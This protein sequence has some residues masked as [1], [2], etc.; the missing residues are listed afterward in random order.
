MKV[1]ILAGGRGTRLSEETNLI[2][3]PLVEIGGIPIIEHLIN[4]YTNQGFNDF[5][6][7]GGYKYEL[8]NSWK[9]KLKFNIRIDIVDTGLET[10]TGGRIKQ[11]LNAYP[12]QKMFLTYGDGLA[13]INLSALLK[14]HNESKKQMTLTCVRPPARF[15]HVELNSKLEVKHFVEKSQL[16]EGWINGGFMV[17]NPEIETYIKNDLTSFESETLPLI[18]SQNNLGAYLH[19]DFWHSMDTL[20]DKS[21]L[22]LIYKNNARR[23]IDY[24]QNLS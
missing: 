21:E 17:I 1:L 10:Q 19:K 15:G 14:R 23:W 13:N 2:P 24:D 3:K 8:F 20:R 11:C 18:A 9:N 5:V 12:N 4:I 6:V 7:A 22:E 16:N